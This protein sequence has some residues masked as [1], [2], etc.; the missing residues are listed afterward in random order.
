MTLRPSHVFKVS[1]LIDARAVAALEAAVRAADPAATIAASLPASLVEI[2]S[3]LPTAALRRAIENAGFP[4]ESSARSLPPPSPYTGRA[5]AR[6]LGRA[7]LWALAW[8]LLAP[9]AALV[10]IVVLYATNSVCGTPGDSGG[11]EMGLASIVMA[12]VPTGFALGF[13]ATLVSGLLRLRPAPPVP[14]QT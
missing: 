13:L 3:R 12:L 10:P 11:C 8:S 5:L 7:A 6:V 9:L 2:V 4:A 1:G 14:P